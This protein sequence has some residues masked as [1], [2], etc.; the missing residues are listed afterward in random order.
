MCRAKPRVGTFPKSGAYDEVESKS[1][2][3]FWNCPYPW[4]SLI[5]MQKV[6]GIMKFN[7]GR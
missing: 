7:R 6:N 1:H 3:T 5:R 4:A 2:S